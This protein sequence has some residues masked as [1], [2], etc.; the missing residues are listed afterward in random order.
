MLL[1][2]LGACA[3]PRSRPVD[4]A[5]QAQEAREAQLSAQG[6]WGLRGRVSVRS[7]RG[8]GSG[9]VDWQASGAHTDFLLQAPISRRSWHLRAGPGQAELLGLEE[10][11]QTAADAETLL[12]DA[13]GWEM[14][15]A[16]L[17]YWVRGA[18]AP[19]AARIRFN[20]QGLPARIEQAGWVIEYPEWRSAEGLPM[21]R[22]VFAERA[23]DRVRMVVDQWR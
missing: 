4:L 22:K 23:A 7:D 13:V 21:P 9:S 19:G 14:P 5:L 12:R 8:Q 18:R 16:S 20:A 1:M 11:V 15:I 2:L 3:G 10:G 17:A 6:D